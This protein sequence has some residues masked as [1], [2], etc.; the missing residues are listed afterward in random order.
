LAK[1]AL[2]F[3]KRWLFSRDVAFNLGRCPKL[4]YVALSG[5]QV[6]ATDY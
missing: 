1:N 2:N 3:D 6:P 5:L 4:G